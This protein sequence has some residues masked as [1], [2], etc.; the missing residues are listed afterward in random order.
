M[1]QLRPRQEHR[2]SRSKSN[3]LQE[4]WKPGQTRKDHKTVFFWTAIS[5][6]DKISFERL[7]IEP[8]AHALV[9]TRR[10]ISGKSLDPQSKAHSVPTNRLVKMK[11]ANLCLLCYCEVFPF[12]P[13]HCAIHCL[14][15]FIVREVK[16]W[17]FFSICA[18]IT[19][20]STL[21]YVGLTSL[22]FAQLAPGLPSGR[23]FFEWV[24]KLKHSPVQ[25]LIVLLLFALLGDCSTDPTCS[26]ACKPGE[27]FVAAS[28]VW[29]G[30]AG[31]VARSQ[32]WRCSPDCSHD[33]VTNDS[34][35]CHA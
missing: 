31:Q 16:K 25:A 35:C 23:P 21:R 24:Y 20:L 3:I 10:W 14:S 30:R 6:S 13:F 34:V 12:L 33:S 27:V 32:Y 15:S 2:G 17:T 29:R 11:R 7:V 9:Y 26:S 18:S 8:Y 28:S 5:Q 22:V 1:H 19:L 4:N